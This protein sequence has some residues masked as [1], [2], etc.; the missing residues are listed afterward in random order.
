M[1]E[2]TVREWA[3][4]LTIRLPEDRVETV[5]AQLEGQIAERGGLAPE[6]LEGIEPAIVFEP[7]WAE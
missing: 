2:E 7:E 1:N 3:R 5:T 6:E 4:M